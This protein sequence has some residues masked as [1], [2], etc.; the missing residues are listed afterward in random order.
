MTAQRLDAIETRLQSV[1]AEASSLM[2]AGMGGLAGGMQRGSEG[3]VA[4][5]AEARKTVETLQGKVRVYLL[6]RLAVGWCISFFV[7]HSF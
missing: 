7:T 2:S 5:M 1:I 3:G 4:E 6:V